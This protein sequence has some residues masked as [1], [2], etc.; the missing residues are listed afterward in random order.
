[1]FKLWRY[2]SLVL[3]DE[4]RN[5]YD[6]ITD[7]SNVHLGDDDFSHLADI[8]RLFTDSEVNSESSMTSDE[9]SDDES[10]SEEDQGSCNKTQQNIYEISDHGSNDSAYR[11]SSELSGGGSDDDSKGWLK[12]DIPGITLLYR[13]DD[14]TDYGSSDSSNEDDAG[15]TH[16]GGNRTTA[17]TST[18]KNYSSNF[19]CTST[20]GTKRKRFDGKKTDDEGEGQN[21][22][23][24]HLARK[25]A[26][27]KLSP[28]KH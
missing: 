18:A 7:Y 1:M 3:N 4:L 23:D 5:A 17:Q 20:R 10:S 12:D 11:G 24:Q 16:H 22:T 26:R 19:E 13:Q 9:P 14:S 2:P 6:T 27:V 8:D 21:D 28:W 15:E 25:I